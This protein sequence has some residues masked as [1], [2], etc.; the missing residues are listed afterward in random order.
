MCYVYEYL[1]VLREHLGKYWILDRCLEHE[2]SFQARVFRIKTRLIRIKW[3]MELSDNRQIPPYVF[4]VALQK[5]LEKEV[6]DPKYLLKLKK[7][8][9]YL[10]SD[11]FFNISSK[12]LK[13]KYSSSEEF[14]S[15][16][17]Q[18][19]KSNSRVM[20]IQEEFDSYQDFHE[21]TNDP[22]TFVKY[23]YLHHL[24]RW[25]NA[26]L[27]RFS[28][29]IREY[30]SLRVDIRYYI[31]F[32]IT[33]RKYFKFMLD[34]YKKDFKSKQQF[35][36]ISLKRELKKDE[37]FFILDALFQDAKFHPYLESPPKDAEEAKM[38]HQYRRFFWYRFL[39]PDLNNE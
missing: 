4:F 26:K 39:F 15:E 16:R 25:N 27:M 2:N 5:F 38:D 30:F 21:E 20:V 3:H 11:A 28:Q 9:W 34:N 6:Q 1:T 33:L 19:M 24:Y 36:E 37:I 32:Q 35:F 12:E 31:Y 13:K 17:S 18:K 10:L 7:I 29:C 22:D 23:E 14:C 8:I